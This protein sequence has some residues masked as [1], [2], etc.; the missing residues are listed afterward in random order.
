VELPDDLEAAIGAAPDDRASYLVAADWLQQQGDPH[1]ELIALGCARSALGADE[2]PQRSLEMSM[3][4]AELQRQVEPE[5][6]NHEHQRM[7]IAWRWGFIAGVR[8]ISKQ[9]P[10]EPALL[11]TVLRAPCAR[12]LR[13]VVLSRVENRKLLTTLIDEVSVLRHVG[14]LAIEAGGVPSRP[15]EL[16]RFWS[17]LGRLEE[18][19]LDLPGAR[20]AIELPELVELSIT[21]RARD[22]D[23]LRNAKLP[24][25]HT[26][27]VDLEEGVSLP[28][29]WIAPERA[30]ALRRLSLSNRSGIDGA[31]WSRSAIAGQLELLE[32]IE[33]SRGHETERRSILERMQRRPSSPPA[34]GLLVLECGGA[35][36]PGTL[37]AL[38]EAG[39][40]DIGRDNVN[41]DATTGYP[42]S[43][44]PAGVTE[45]RRRVAPAA[46]MGFQYS[47]DQAQLR[48]EPRGWVV[49]ESSGLC[50]NRHQ[51]RR[52]P[53]R[54]G[55]ELVV[56]RMTFRFLEGD[57]ERLA[58]EL[59]GRL[60]LEATARISVAGLGT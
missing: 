25:L 39:E 38:P 48:R 1:G 16:E 3:R 14:A 36:A 21:C 60:A 35:P 20:G 26:L 41:T 12:F 5:L 6:T 8:L 23:L 27:R 57:I 9:A 47:H 19:V 34:A 56:G 46:I 18:L 51:T 44:Y 10:D 40:F 32:L 13:Q 17:Q 43:Y 58:G 22:T 15:I 2:P 28:C 52:I 31:A 29:E 55:D 42:Y 59:R 37:I 24:S 45:R 11:R 4:I 7:R 53:L 54:S 50:V 33:Y 30:P 49:R